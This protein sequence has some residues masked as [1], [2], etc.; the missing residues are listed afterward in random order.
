MFRS[1]LRVRAR[2]A[3][4][5]TLTGLAVLA[6]VLA[7]AWTATVQPAYVAQVGDA[8]PVVEPFAAIGLTEPSGTTTGPGSTAR[9]SSLGNTGLTFTVIPVSLTIAKSHS[10]PFIQGEDGVYTITVGN[11]ATASPTNGTTVTVHDR[12]PEGLRADRISGA[13][14]TCI[15]ATLTCTR[16]DILPAG[17]S[18]PPITLNVDVSCHAR[19][20]VTNTATVTGGGDSTTHTATDPTTI[21]RHGHDGDGHGGH[22]GHHDHCDGHD[23][24]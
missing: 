14:W 13:G 5:V 23:H 22:D 15:P 8:T 18:Y 24:W 3:G 9:T 2:R 1:W 11:L 17:H 16:S 20:R 6:I 19:E 12:L 7:T 10:D 21:K 4:A